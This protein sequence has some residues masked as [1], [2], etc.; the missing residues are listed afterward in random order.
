MRFRA[1]LERPD[2]FTHPTGSILALL[3]HH[4]SLGYEQIAAIFASR[5]TKSVT[6]SRGYANAD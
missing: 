1:E 2:G 6:R 5:L 3:E 4:G